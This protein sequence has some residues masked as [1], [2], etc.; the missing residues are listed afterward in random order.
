MD[1]HQGFSID[2]ISFKD[3]TGSTS[4]S[5]TLNPGETVFLSLIIPDT[6]EKW[7]EI[8]AISASNESVQFNLVLKIKDLAVPLQ[9]NE[10]TVTV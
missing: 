6:Q 10:L 3:E 9:S 2:G 1:V 7:D 5:V 8:T 4:T